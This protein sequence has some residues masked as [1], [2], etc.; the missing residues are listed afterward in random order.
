MKDLKIEIPEGHEIDQE[1]STFEKIIFKK[2]GKPMEWEYI[3]KID[4]YYVDTASDLISVQSVAT[5]LGNNKNV[6]PTKQD[7]ASSLALA[8][9]LQLRKA[10]IGEWEAIWDGGRFMYVITRC[11]KSLD[12]DCLSS[13]YSELSF[14]SEEMA[15]DFLEAFKDLIKVYYKL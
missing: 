1:K 14:P 15:L 3:K 8:Q 7:A 10:W 13:S 4:G 2:V 9:L 6:F 12:I 11:K 5:I